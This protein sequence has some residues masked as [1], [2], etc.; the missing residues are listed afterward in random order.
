[1]FRFELSIMI[2]PFPFPR[3][4]PRNFIFCSLI[5]RRKICSWKFVLGKPGTI[6]KTWNC[7]ENREL[8]FFPSCSLLSFM[9]SLSLFHTHTHTHK[10]TTYL[11][12]DPS[13]YV[14][15]LSLSLSLSFFVSFFL[16][17]SLSDHLFVCLSACMYT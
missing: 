4:R 6:W 3:T 2:F 10:H 13:N 7:S 9:L 12:F 15:S 5:S 8:F 16:S 11:S 14:F 1:M 17:F